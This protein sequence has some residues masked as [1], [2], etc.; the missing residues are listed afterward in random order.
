MKKARGR[1]KKD[2]KAVESENG[3][4]LISALV[5]KA[6]SATPAPAPSSHL[7]IDVEAADNSPPAVLPQPSLV[8]QKPVAD[9]EAKKARAAEKRAAKKAKQDEEARALQQRKAEEEALLAAE[10][11]SGTARDGD[12]S[13]PLHPPQVLPQTTLPRVTDV[14]RSA[15]N[16]WNKTVSS[17]T[18]NPKTVLATGTPRPTRSKKSMTEAM[19]M[20]KYPKI[21]K[22]KSQKSKKS[23]A[24]N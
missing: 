16:T 11:G 10:A 21:T 6:N 19:T 1:P 3:D 13:A 7:K 9:L 17:T 22:L 2:K 4:D 24:Q 23:R 8:V 18:L 12:L 20:S 15:R 14:T 5:A